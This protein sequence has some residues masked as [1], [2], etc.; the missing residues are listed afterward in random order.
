VADD[1]DDVDASMGGS[2]GGQ[3]QQAT[4]NHNTQ[5]LYKYNPGYNANLLH[6]N[7]M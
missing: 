3:P 4:P 5:V 6:A 2:P 7:I 1:D